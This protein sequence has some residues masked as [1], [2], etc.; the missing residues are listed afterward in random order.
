MLTLEL[1]QG[2]LSSAKAVR[3]ILPF[4]ETWVSDWKTS[5]DFAQPLLEVGVHA[6]HSS[7]LLLAKLSLLAQVSG[8]MIEFVAS[9]LMVVNEFPIT[10]T[11]DR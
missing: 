8:K 5:A 10:V 7:G 9:I 4:A 11:H 3:S 6:G 1:R 2:L